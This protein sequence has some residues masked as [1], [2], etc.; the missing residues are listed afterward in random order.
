MKTISI[1]LMLVLSI[2][3]LRADELQIA[4]EALR[5]GLWD[6]ARSHAEKLESDEARLVIL[7]AYS[8]E[9]RWNDVLASLDK[10][11][12]EGKVDSA[13]AFIYYRALALAENNETG[14]AK[15][16]L[17]EVE[18]KTA[19]YK[20]LSARLKA[21]LYS[22]AGESKK[23]LEAIEQSKLENASLNE[24]ISIA[25]IMYSS[26][27]K[28]GAKKI[29]QEVA[30]HTNEPGRAFAIAAALLE[31]MELLKIAA[32][33]SKSESTRRFA[34][35]KRARLLIKD[36]AHFEEGAKTIKSQVR[37]APDSEGALDAAIALAEA[38]LDRES[39]QEAADAFRNILEIWPEA[40]RRANVQ[41]G[42]GWAARKLGKNEEALEAFSRAEEMATDDEAKA[43]AI[44]E[45]GDTL[46]DLAK[47][48]EA[49]VKYRTIL[50]KYPETKAANKLKEV[51]EKRDLETKG[52][53]LYRE[54][55]FAEAEKVFA[56]LGES[57]P[58]LAPRAEFLQVLCLYGQGQDTEAE[59]RAKKISESSSDL[60][61]RAEATLWL[62]KL[63]FNSQ[64]WEESVKL[65]TQFAEMSPD[66]PRAAGSLVWAARAAFSGSDFANSVKMVSTLLA[67]Y[68][69]SSEKG[70]AYAVQGE[71]LM[72]LGRYDEAVLVFEMALLEGGLTAEE[73][74]NVEVLKADALFSMGADNPARYRAA[75][76][77]YRAVRQG[78]SLS[79]G[80]RLAISFKMGRTLEKLKR[81]DEA[82]DQYYAG[83]VLAYR[84]G[85]LKGI[86]F[87]DE[88]RAAFAKAAFRLA[89]E[90]ES[91]GKD[92]QAMHILELVI[93]S[94]VPAS[95]EAEK[96]LE[97]IQT[98]GKLL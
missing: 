61:I 52:R 4:K 50:D 10:W 82:I 93:A 49:M 43:M 39:W 26:G 60:T 34:A 73:R 98:K 59:E 11:R 12:S 96:R 36:A 14:K 58:E 92:F 6:V 45:T 27:N 9:K 83:V 38:Y 13:D 16:I 40:S 64:R 72:E 21:Q 24:K 5:D 35:L 87:D 19:E 23:A 48:E 69:D 31:D 37:D 1:V 41:E 85:R 77:A 28:E 25:E 56:E 20:E 2:S 54:Y 68:P 7:E 17:D 8:K 95:D 67:R 32:E 76:D 89:D 44:L 86:A 90:Y 70:R 79:P 74:L 46:S 75:L 47:G 66:S 71:A 65:F 29:W 22:A 88:A 80:M 33:N 91:R 94:D 62:A 81:I 84:E 78:E 15:K 97:R 53:K 57:D 42:A 63:A 3:I 55:R 30:A 18:F 51:V